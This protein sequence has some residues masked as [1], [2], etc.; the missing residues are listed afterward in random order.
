MTVMKVEL[1]MEIG[2]LTELMVKGFIRER[3]G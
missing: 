3:R 1:M 2:G